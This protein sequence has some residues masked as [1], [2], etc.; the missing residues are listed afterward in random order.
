MKLLLEI[1]GVILIVLGAAHAVFR[2]YFR[3]DEETKGLSLLTRE[4]LHVHTWFIGLTVLMIGLLSLTSADLLLHSPLGKRVS[5]GLAVF[6]GLRL[7]VQF[8]VYSPELW[9]GKRFET[10]MHV[11]FTLLWVFL[12]AAYGVAAA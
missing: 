3:W 7:V 5:L 9:K 10:T 12:T 4:V 2:R 1:A 11:L 8:F 6:W